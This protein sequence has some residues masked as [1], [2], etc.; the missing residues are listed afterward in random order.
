MKEEKI[1]TLHPEGKN[2]VNISRTKYDFIK[3]EIIKILKEHNEL[4]FTGLLKELNK[5]LK[6]KFT[7]SVSWYGTVVK[8]D[9]E[10]RKILYCSRRKPKQIVELVKK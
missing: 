8:L 4:T 6:N 9:L 5:K 10:A 1:L 7:G 2:G 3:S